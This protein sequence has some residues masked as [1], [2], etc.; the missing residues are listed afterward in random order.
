MKVGMPYMM[1]KLRTGYKIDMNENAI[2]SVGRLYHPGI[3][4]EVLVGSFIVS[5]NKEDETFVK[6][7]QIDLFINGYLRYVQAEDIT[8]DIS[9]I[10]G[11]AGPDNALL[12]RLKKYKESACPVINPDLIDNIV[13]FLRETNNDNLPAGVNIYT[14]N[15]PS[16]KEYGTLWKDEGE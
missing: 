9:N 4:G 13:E 14:T 5:I 8:I 12:N 3:K 1:R 16:F 10:E 6:H 11:F 7:R 2:S 15:K